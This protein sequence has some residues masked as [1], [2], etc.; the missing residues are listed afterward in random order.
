VLKGHSIRKV[1]THWCIRW[2]P[3]M[4]MRKVT[5]TRVIQPAPGTY[6]ALGDHLGN[7]FFRGGL[8]AWS[9]PST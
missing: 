2:F 1:E 7:K 6:M 3:Y 8:K 9:V 5:F 4:Q